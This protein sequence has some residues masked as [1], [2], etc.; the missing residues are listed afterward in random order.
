MGGGGGNSVSGG[1]IVKVP[2]AEVSPPP[3]G[4]PVLTFVV[5]VT[6]TE[7]GVVTSDARIVAEADVVLGVV[8]A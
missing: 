3:K 1:L 4:Q 2:G 5:I 8:V 6:F 7:P